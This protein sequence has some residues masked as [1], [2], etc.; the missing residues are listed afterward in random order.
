MADSVTAAADPDRDV[1]VT[2]FDV[3][4]KFVKGRRTRSIRGAA[5]NVFLGRELIEHF[6]DID[7]AIELARKVAMRSGRPSWMTADGNSFETIG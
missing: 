3:R 5:W 6:E 2:P 4:L 7:D 1:L